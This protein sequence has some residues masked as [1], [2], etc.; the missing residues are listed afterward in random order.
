MNEPVF[1]HFQS[2]IWVLNYSNLIESGKWPQRTT[3]YTN[4]PDLVQTSIRGGAKF[5]APVE[6]IAEIKARLD[7]TGQDGKAAYF[8][9]AFGIPIEDIAELLNWDYSMTKRRINRAIAF[10]C[11]YKRRRE[12][13]RDFTHYRGK[14]SDNMAQ[15]LKLT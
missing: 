12:N 8:H 4:N 13:Y 7:L 3:G 6:V 1:Y 15:G 11:G 9:H 5:V 14:R 10:S 2:I